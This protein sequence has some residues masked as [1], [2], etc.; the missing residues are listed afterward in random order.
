LNGHTATNR[1]E[2]LQS[3]H[4]RHNTYNLR[5]RKTDLAPPMPKREFGNR[6]FSYN[7]ALHWNNLPHEAK[8]SE[9]LYKLFQIDTKTKNELKL[10]RV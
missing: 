10:A 7:G 3:N 9:S 5:K 1:K 8:I 2:A 6:C 4:E